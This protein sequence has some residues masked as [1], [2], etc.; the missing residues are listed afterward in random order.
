MPK[1]KNR[2]KAIEINKDQEKIQT[3]QDIKN[4]K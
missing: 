2:Y 3:I 1:G 4:I